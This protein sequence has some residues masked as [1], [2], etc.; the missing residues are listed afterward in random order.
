MWKV[1]PNKHVTNF[2]S[3]RIIWK[4]RY[5][6]TWDIH[7]KYEPGKYQSVVVVTTC[8]KKNMIT[9]VLFLITRGVERAM[10]ARTLLVVLVL[11]TFRKRQL[12]FLKTVIGFYI[13][14]FLCTF[15]DEF[16]VVTSWDA[17]FKLLFLRRYKA[18][19]RFIYFFPAMYIYFFKFSCKNLEKRKINNSFQN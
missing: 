15:C 1:L 5:M 13:T 4:K 19:Y 10:I 8:V 16:K 12:F 11:T 14:C 17:Y 7:T 18:E 6:A 3:K 2:T 9:F